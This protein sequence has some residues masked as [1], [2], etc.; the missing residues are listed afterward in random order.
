MWAGL[1]TIG[2]LLVAMIVACYWHKK[3]HGRWI[4]Q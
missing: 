1:G 2:I 3:T 4:P